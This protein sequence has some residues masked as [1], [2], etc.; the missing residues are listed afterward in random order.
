M[1]RK[2]MQVGALALVAL[3]VIGVALFG[4][5]YLTHLRDD[6]RV[7]L[8]GQN[9][10]LIKRAQFIG[11]ASAHQE[12]ALSIG[13]QL[14][15]QAQLT[16]LLHDM[17][18]PHSTLYHHFLT[19]QQFAAEFSPTPDQIQQVVQYLRSQGLTVSAVAPNGLFIDASADV[20]TV[21][22]AFQVKI[23]QY[24]LGP[25]AF[26][27]N[28][29]PPLLPVSIAPLILSIGG[30]DDSVHMHPLLQHSPSSMQEKK[31]LH[32]LAGYSS[33]D[34]LGAYDAA[35]LQQSSIQ[36][37]G[38]SVAVFELDGFQQSDIDTFLSK[39]NLGTPSITTSLVDGATNTAG[40]GA[41]EVELDIEVIAEMAP[42]ASQDVY[43]G[44][45]S[46]QGVND[47]YN[48]IVT[49]N[50][51]QI[52]STSWGECEAQ[53]G[54][55]ELQALDTI[56]QQGTAQG[57][58]FFSAAGD[59]GAYDC[60]DTNLAVDSP[61]SDP[62]VTGV[63]GT[64][65]QT[66]NGTY[67]SESVWSSPTDTQRSPE[68]SGGGGGISSYFSIPS[69]QT[70]PGVQNQYSNGHREV[71]DIS[72]DAD[73]QTGYA[74]YCTVVAAGCPATG[75]IVVGG[76][77]AAAPLWAGSMALMNEYLQKQGHARAGF[78]TPTLYTLASSKPS[79]PAFHDVTSGTNLFYPATANY[80][81]GSGIGSPDV[82][83]LA[84]DLSGT[85]ST[86][87]PTPVPTTQ[88]VPTATAI[89]VPTVTSVPV[90]TAT[91]VPV[92]TPTGVVAPPAPPA[93]PSGSLIQN[94]DFESG[95]VGWQESSAGGYELVDSKNPHSGQYS[96]YLCGYSD[97][98]DV[99]SQSFVVPS[100]S[101]QLTLSYWWDGTT[102]ST[103][104][105]CV[106]TFSALLLDSSGNT[107]K[108]LQQA[109]NT[110]ATGQ[111]QQK[112]IDLSGALS[113]YAGQS[114]TLVFSGRTGASQ[115]TSS[116][117]VDDVSLG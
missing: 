8:S 69:W 103:A 23:N 48:K 3:L 32:P 97:C 71:P 68:G 75:D 101:S 93:P 63:G 80:D 2:L 115:Q 62:Y 55:S 61:A 39:N 74:I 22:G 54:N 51:T 5:S 104:S 36:G 18:N 116:F 47:T 105:S 107:I 35:A 57:I 84:R 11:G 9:V 50:T 87:T 65:L 19:P 42:K 12:L 90:P 112:T 27:A 67:G 16:A 20:A 72:A 43:I 60:N 38:Q 117:F 13:L 81:M 25:R 29:T 1:S 58:T 30:M 33:S 44:P 82:Y 86:P 21:E 4:F 14:R 94:G 7:S 102:N 28:A 37:S 10:P 26:Y 40:A 52:A 99:I 113:N 95:V 41:I 92:P 89:P 66:N 91:L 34:L 108:Q 88:P 17:Y 77:S 78:I 45:N 100:G 24:K 76:T 59:S 110:D 96:A 85:T 83:N 56:F 53:S 6:Q 31:G 15:N 111:W 70:G 109:C 79:Y 49:D 46:T 64:N 98:N 114:V 106:D 73:P